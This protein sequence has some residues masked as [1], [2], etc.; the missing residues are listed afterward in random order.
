[1]IYLE[2]CGRGSFAITYFLLNIYDFAVVEESVL[3]YQSS[4]KP[5]PQQPLFLAR[6][7]QKFP[8]RNTP[9]RR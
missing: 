1:M 4:Q 6:E 8:T 3:R 7:V 2:W 9:L 5:T